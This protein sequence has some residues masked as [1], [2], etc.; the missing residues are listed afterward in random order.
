MTF[1]LNLSVKHFSDCT[2]SW[3]QLDTEQLTRLAISL[4]PT[5]PLMREHKSELRIELADARSESGLIVLINAPPHSASRESMTAAL[6]TIL[7]APVFSHV[8]ALWAVRHLTPIVLAP[9]IL[10]MLPALTTLGMIFDERAHV[11]DL[12]GVLAVAQQGSRYPTACPRLETLC[13]RN[14]RGTEQNAEII[15]DI[16]ESRAWDGLRVRRLAIESPEPHH[17]WKPAALRTFV[18][19]LVIR[20]RFEDEGREAQLPREWREDPQCADNGVWPDWV[21]Y[22]V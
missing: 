12:R 17:A 6:S 13:L 20:A 14:Y 19:E 2:S 16:V 9:S 21:V 18:D 1:H 4:Q 5:S 11:T 7:S 10:Q 8:L 15:R 22:D 3:L